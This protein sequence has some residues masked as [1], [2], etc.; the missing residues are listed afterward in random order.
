LPE[1]SKMGTLAESVEYIVEHAHLY[2]N[3]LMDGQP[4]I[5]LLYRAIDLLNYE[6][7]Q[8]EIRSVFEVGTSIEQSA[9][10]Q[11]LIRYTTTV[12]QQSDL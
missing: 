3:I 12:N 7:R 5:E 6:W 11:Q 8:L 1:F 9:I 4:I 2:K 10:H